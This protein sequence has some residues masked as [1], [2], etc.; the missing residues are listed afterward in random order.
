MAGGE[1]G[2]S[3]STSMATAS[4]QPFAAPELKTIYDDP[5]TLTDVRKMLQ[6]LK[7]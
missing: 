2:K 5:M 3:N 4:S 1:E 6:A 7:R